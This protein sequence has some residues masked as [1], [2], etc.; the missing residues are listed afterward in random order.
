MGQTVCFTGALTKP[1]KLKRA[2]N[3]IEMFST[4][5]DR[6]AT[7]FCCVVEPTPRDHFKGLASVTLWGKNNGSGG[8]ASARIRA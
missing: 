4:W 5:C 7:P 2:C 1:T 6:R 8:I 3:E